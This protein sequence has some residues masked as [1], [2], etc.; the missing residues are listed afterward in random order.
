MLRG[1]LKFEAASNSLSLFPQN[2]A[3]LKRK[4]IRD[5]KSPAMA[6]LPDGASPPLP[7]VSHP[8]PP[9]PPMPSADSF[10]LPASLQALTPAQARFCLAAARF[11]KQDLDLDLRGNSLLIG[12]SGGAD[13]LAL[14]L[15]LHYLTPS[16][17]L[18]L[19]A[20][21]LDHGLRPSSAQEADFCRAFCRRLGIAC[22]S[23]Q[24]DIAGQRRRNKTGIEEEGRAARYGFFART[25]AR[26]GSDWIVTGHQNDDLA[27]DLLMRLIRGAGW[28]ALSG[29]PAV[30]RERR[31]LRPFLLTPRKD[32]ENFLASL[33]LTWLRDESNED[34]AYLRN[35]VRM[36][37]IPLILRE[38]P[39]FL[40]NVAGLWK[41]GR[42]D[43]D[44]FD[45]LLPSLDPDAD[46]APAPERDA[47]AAPATAPEAD[48]AAAPEA[49]PAIVMR[50]EQ[51]EDLPKALRLR[52]YKKTLS[53]LGPGQPLLS[54]L[55][56]VD[57]AWLA[58]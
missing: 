41:L 5:P 11:L 2:F 42:I 29:M 46:A 31:L 52:F 47:D 44:H 26:I 13:S 8:L 49:V 12:F 15:V 43:E 16:L 55:L 18:R 10:R 53:R 57:R 27:E 37:L 33:G 54:V 21:H 14:L 51:L 36:D 32:I 1:R 17:H 38:N 19:A 35:R 56:A 34:R 22:L 20:A 40:T 39:A 45:A 4:V 30:D 9:G 28:P 24:R 25:A 50:R 58:G 23:E 48:I 6:G 7:R 3:I